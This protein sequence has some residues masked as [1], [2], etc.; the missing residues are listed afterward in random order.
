MS[1]IGDVSVSNSSAPSS[2][3]ASIRSRPCTPRAPRARSPSA[4]TRGSST[5]SCRAST[6]L[7][8]DDA[9]RDGLT[10][11]P[12]V[13][14]ALG[15]YGRGELH[16]SSDIDLMVVHDGEQ[17]PFV[18][19]VT[20]E[21]LYTLWD[22]GFQVG[23][24]L[25]S[26]DDCVAMARTDFPSRTSM[27]EARLVAGDR[28]ALHALPPGAAR[29][30]LSAATSASSWPHDAGRARPALPQVRRRSPYIGEPNVKESAGGL[31]DMHTAMWLGAAKFGARTLRELVGQGAHHAPRAGRH[32]RGPDLPVARAQR[33]ALPVRPQERRAHARPPAADRQDLRLRERRARASA[34][35]ASCATTTCTRA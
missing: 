7:M 35:S 5:S 28:R 18:Q 21:L 19:R 32:R 33:A 26:L 34:S 24:S 3:R 16:P 10:P 13:V 22:L 4:R 15:G 8:V 20:Q 12:L 2:P 6:R 9:R 11:T 1:R 30:R 29:Q 17:T 25:R 23:H 27:Q 31:R 14:V